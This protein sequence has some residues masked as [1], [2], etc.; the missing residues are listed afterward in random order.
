MQPSNDEPD[1]LPD[2][3]VAHLKRREGAVPTVAPAVDRA[4]LDAARRQFASRPHPSAASVR[5]FAVPLAAAATILLAVL[6]VRPFD[7]FRGG[8]PDDVD[9]SGSVNILD[10]FALARLRAARGD[11]SGVTEERIDMLVE[12][13]VALGDAGGSR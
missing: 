12:R 3:I 2:A 7:G 5:R 6:L 11:A 10:A 13:V 4:V 9:G 8:A 1:H